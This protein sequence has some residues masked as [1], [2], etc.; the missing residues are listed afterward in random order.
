MVV[1][2]TNPKREIELVGAIRKPVGPL[3]SGARGPDG[4]NDLGIDRR[5]LEHQD[6]VGPVTP[7][8]GS[9]SAPDRASEQPVEKLGPLFAARHLAAERLERRGDGTAGPVISLVELG[10]Q[11]DPE[12]GEHQSTT[13]S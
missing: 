8:D 6:H 9:E 3:R 10:D 1:A 11:N 7:D 2:G 12:A 13:D 5:A 4:R